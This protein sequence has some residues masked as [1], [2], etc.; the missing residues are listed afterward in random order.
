MKESS[1]A[2]L[3]GWGG[4]HTVA[5]SIFDQVYFS[6]YWFICLE[7]S[8][9]KTV[10]WGV[11]AWSNYTNKTEKWYKT[12]CRTEGNCIQVI[13]LFVF[14]LTNPPFSLKSNFIQ[15]NIDYCSF[16][17]EN[18]SAL[19]SFSHVFI[20]AAQQQPSKPD[21]KSPEKHITAAG[22]TSLWNVLEL[23]NH[24]TEASTALTEGCVHGCVCVSALR[25]CLLVTQ[26][27]QKAQ[28]AVS[29]SIVTSK[30]LQT[31]RQTL[32]MFMSMYMYM[33]RDSHYAHTH[34]FQETVAI[35]C[36]HF[37]ETPCQPLQPRLLEEDFTHTHPS[38][39]ALTLSD[40]YIH[41]H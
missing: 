38:V 12:V 16:K 6:S 7:K 19:I 9:L 28:K 33:Y 32:Y 25:M 30:I 24:N 40:A 2:P 36:Q 41:T 4:K 15:K 3:T 17:K 21:I 10:C 27:F 20:T 22:V 35:K 39:H 18:Y 13:I 37:L 31:H 29:Q 23:H 14:A 11:Q 26:S 8:R 5:G 34:T 1:P